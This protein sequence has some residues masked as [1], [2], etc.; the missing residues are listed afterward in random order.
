MW[1]WVGKMKGWFE[2]IWQMYF[3]IIY[4]NR[5]MKF[6][7]IVLRRGEWENVGGVKSKIYCKDTYK[8]HISFF[9]ADYM[10]KIKKRNTHW[11]WRGRKCMS[12]SEHGYRITLCDFC[13]SV[14]INSFQNFR[15]FHRL[16]ARQMAWWE[17]VVFD[18]CTHITYIDI[19]IHIHTKLFTSYITNNLCLY[20][21]K[22][23]TYFIYAFKI[24]YVIWII[25]IYVCILTHT[26]VKVLSQEASI[27]KRL[28]LSTCW[29]FTYNIRNVSQKHSHRFFPSQPPQWRGRKRH[30]NLFIIMC[31]LVMWDA[32]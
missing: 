4:E 2:W 11:Q 29:D 26:L 8:N 30:T 16:Q 21:C 32:Q 17:E 22:Y 24:I 3:V 13:N 6:V 25:N 14:Q 18:L 19:Y 7:E 27:I 15:D 31:S 9:C 12:N 20:I 5:R 28:W 23:W 1:N 10:L